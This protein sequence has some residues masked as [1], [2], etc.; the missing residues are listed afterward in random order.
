[1]WSDSDKTPRETQAPAEPYVYPPAKGAGPTPKPVP[2]SGRNSTLERLW[3]SEAPAPPPVSE[4]QIRAREEA[5]RQAGWE[6]GRQEG[7]LQ[8]WGEY[9]KK[10]E[11]ERATVTAAVSD[12]A[13]ERESYFSR[14]EGEVV[15][16]AL[17]IARKILHREA[18]VDPLLLAGVVRVALEKVAIGTRVR[19]R[20]PPDQVQAWQEFFAQHPGSPTVPELMGD[21][22]LG[23]GHCLLETELGSTDL[24]LETQLKEIE[25]GFFDLLAQRP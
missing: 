19:L 20:V 11:A 16:L 7:E 6:K 21:D 12:F 2:A 10:V 24:T 4:D 25:Q 5:A 17:A 1:M 13:K 3:N 18:Q 15:G 23:P 22:A 8:V 14:V 9:Q